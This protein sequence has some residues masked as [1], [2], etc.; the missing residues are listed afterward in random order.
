MTS[1]NQAHADSERLRAFADELSLFSRRIKDLDQELQQGL[2]R[3]GETF[4]DGE[5]EKFRTHFRSS[6]QKLLGFVEE[7]QSLVPKLR[8]DADDLAASERTKLEI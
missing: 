7:V 6:R 2:A 1:P 5:Y 3:L 8:V 4:Q